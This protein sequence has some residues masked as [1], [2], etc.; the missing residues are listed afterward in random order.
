M[1]ALNGLE[2]T[3]TPALRELLRSAAKD[4]TIDEVCGRLNSIQLYKDVQC[5]MN[6]FDSSRTYFNGASVLATR[7]AL[8]SYH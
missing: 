5:V 2:L 6:S 1:T 4:V 7:G 8:E 3:C